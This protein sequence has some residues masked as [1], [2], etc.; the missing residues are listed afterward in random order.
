MKQN[1]KM[2]CFMS[3]YQY[4]PF[5]SIGV[6]GGGEGHVPACLPEL[7]GPRLP[8]WRATSPQLWRS[9]Y[10]GQLLAH[11]GGRVGHAGRHGQLF[12]VH[13]VQAHTALVG[14]CCAVLMPS[15]YGFVQVPVPVFRIRIRI[16]VLKKQLTP[17]ALKLRYW[18]CSNQPF[19]QQFRN[20]K[21]MHLKL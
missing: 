19:F 11:P 18:S 13:K 15:R 5:L 12:R 1:F 6:Q 2:P 16:Q 21:R 17:F 3:A 4:L 14:R 7:P 20:C 10:L 8:L 9:R